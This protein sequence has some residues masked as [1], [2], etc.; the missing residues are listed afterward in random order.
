MQ[1]VG[2]IRMQKADHRKDGHSAVCRNTQMSLHRTAG[3]QDRPIRRLPRTP[4]ISHDSFDVII[5][6]KRP[7]LQVAPVLLQIQE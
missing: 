4:R 5:L 2:I 7:L 1:F 3:N 6:Q